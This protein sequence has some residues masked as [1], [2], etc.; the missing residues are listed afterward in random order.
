[1]RFQEGSVG[2]NRFLG[3]LDDVSL[4]W[5]AWMSSSVRRGHL[6]VVSDV[7]DV[8]YGTLSVPARGTA[9]CFTS[10]RQ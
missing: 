8:F 6:E 4:F 5:C 10:A 2:S 3:S 1:M 7:P 9:M